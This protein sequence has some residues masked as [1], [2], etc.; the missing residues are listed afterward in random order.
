MRNE[1]FVPMNG[2]RTLIPHHITRGTSIYGGAVPQL[3][4]AIQKTPVLHK[5]LEGSGIGA[6]KPVG[7]ISPVPTS[8]NPS[9]PTLE[10]TTFSGG[11]LLNS[12]AFGSSGKK[13]AK[14]DNIKFIF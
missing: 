7:I 8:R 10:K 5:V 11:D 9:K 6:N 14:R 12:I 3:R 4:L 13:G 1:R 2:I